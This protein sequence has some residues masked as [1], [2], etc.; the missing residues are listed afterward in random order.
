MDKLVEIKR[1]M[2]H[3]GNQPLVMHIKLADSSYYQVVLS[4][5][6]GN[7]EVC[8]EKIKSFVKIPKRDLIIVGQTEETRQ[9]GITKNVALRKGEQVDG[10]EKGG[11]A[12]AKVLRIKQSKFAHIFVSNDDSFDMIEFLKT[13][14]V[15]I[16]LTVGFSWE[17]HFFKCAG[18]FFRKLTSTDFKTRGCEAHYSRNILLFNQDMEHVNLRASFGACR[19]FDCDV[20]QIQQ[21]KTV[22]VDN[23]RLLMA[24]EDYYS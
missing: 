5:K 16:R 11:V 24:P 19:D 4:D 3:T 17:N 23:I 10:F 13:A 15:E 7:I 12:M 9:L 18:P 1:K 8:K 14:R 2:L 6:K 22:T 20:S 21:M